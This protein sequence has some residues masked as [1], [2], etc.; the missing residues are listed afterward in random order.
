MKLFRNFFIKEVKV[1]R[2]GELRFE[3]K[4]YVRG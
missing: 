3:L 1:N 2:K 4:N